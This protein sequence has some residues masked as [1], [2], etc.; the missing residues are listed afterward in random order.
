[1]ASMG[2]NVVRVTSCRADSL[3]CG[4]GMGV[5]LTLIFICVIG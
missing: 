1:M 5:V 2:E 4:Y 3:I